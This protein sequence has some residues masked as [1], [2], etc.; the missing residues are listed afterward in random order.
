MPSA[1]A[2]AAARSAAQRKASEA[3]GAVGEPEDGV[4]ESSS[5]A[6]QEPQR[7]RRKRSRWADPGQEQQKALEAVDESL[8]QAV[9]KQVQLPNADQIKAHLAGQGVSSELDSEDPEVHRQHAKL[10]D[11]NQR[12]Q[13]GDFDDRR[14]E[15]ERSPSPEP[16][17]DSEGVRQNTRDVRNRER[18]YHQRSE[19]IEFLMKRCP[20]FKPP[21]DWRPP[22]KE[23]K[24]FIPQDDYPGFNFIG[25]IIGPRGNTQKRLQRETNTKIAIRGKGSLKEGQAR[26][27]K[28][29]H[30]EDEDLHVL[31]SGD[32]DEDVEHGAKEVQKLLEP[33]EEQMVQHKREQL[34]ELAM[35]N[36]TLKDNE[37]CY[38]CGK[39]G[40]MQFDCP[41]RNKGDIAGSGPKE[42]VTC[43]ICGEGGHIAA[44]CP[45]KNTDDA[46]KLSE[47]YNSF[48]QEIGVENDPGFKGAPDTEALAKQQL[49]R[50]R[51][52]AQSRGAAGKQQKHVGPGKHH[53]VRA[54]LCLFLLSSESLHRMT[55]SM[56]F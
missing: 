32:S 42:P 31:V 7:K 38:L 35:I 19:I 36:G 46:Q 48:L 23:R 26:D 17:Y 47:E 15:N 4:P 44:D 34:R 8:Q 56:E 30:G 11:I 9:S 14:P 27:P 3:T 54:Y 43:R 2:L 51:D 53:T 45:L 1:E 41:E 55:V 16:V 18:L 10:M 49:Q 52:D 24:V 28:H 13:A 40:H 37:N 22:K 20:G 25:L 29:D 6:N 21:T 39:P 5:D 12:I 33:S 50:S